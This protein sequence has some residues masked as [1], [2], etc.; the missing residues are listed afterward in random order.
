VLSRLLIAESCIETISGTLMAGEKPQN[1]T[2]LK[3]SW[4][5]HGLE[6]WLIFAPHRLVWIA[7]TESQKRYTIQAFGG[8]A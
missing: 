8:I 7:L 3:T 1:I 2:V 6:A 4:Q 5:M